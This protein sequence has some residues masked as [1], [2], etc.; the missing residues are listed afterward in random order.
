MNRDVP[1]V[2][3]IT[4]LA[5]TIELAAESLTA[6]LD[7]SRCEQ[8][9]PVSP[10]QLRVLLLLRAH[11]HLNINGLAEALQVVPSSASRLCDR[12]E[13]L[14]LVS[15]VPDPRDRREM[16][17]PLTQAAVAMLDDLS[18]YRRRALAEVMAAMPQVARQELA[19]SLAAFS[20]AAASLSDQEPDVVRRTA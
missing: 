6:V 19:R 8:L 1:G 13:A 7:P 3:R 2:P 4:D 15:R 11:P 10:A 5:S 14:G 18:D 12:L 20:A 17:L 16:Q 9:T